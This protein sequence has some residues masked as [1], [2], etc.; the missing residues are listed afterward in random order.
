MLLRAATEHDIDLKKS[1]MIGDKLAD[2]QA[3]QK[4][5][6]QTILV[7]TGHGA[8]LSSK[9]ELELIDQCPDLLCAARL[10]LG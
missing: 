4:A 3:G 10:I 6:C 5:G 8:F 2:I 7:L 9:P 1:F